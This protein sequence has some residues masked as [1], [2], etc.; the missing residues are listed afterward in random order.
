[1]VNVPRIATADLAS[2]LRE[3]ELDR[4]R[5]A[6]HIP[7]D[8]E[9]RIPGPEWKANRPPVGWLCVFE[10]QLKGGLRFP[11]PQFV[12]DV[13]NFF[14]VPLAQVVPNG[15]RIVVRF[16]LTCLEKEIA[17][18][19]IA[20]FRYFFQLK[21]AAQAPGCVSFQSRGGFRIRTPYNNFYCKKMSTISVEDRES[22]LLELLKASGMVEMDRIAASNIRNRKRSYPSYILKL[23]PS[24]RELKPFIVADLE[25]ILINN[26]HT[27]YAAGLL[28]VRPGEEINSSQ[29]YTNFSEDHSIIL[30]SFEERSNKV[31]F[32]LVSKI[33]SLVREERE[34]LTIYFHN[35][36]RFDGIFLLKHLACNHRNY[37][38]KPLV[39][40]HRLYEISVYSGK[41][42]LFRL[43]DSLNLLP[44][45]LRSLA[46][47]LCPELGEKGSIP[48]S[49]IYESHL[50]SMKDSL[51][52]YMKQDIL[53]LGGVMHK[54]QR[55][56]Y[57]LF[58]VD[59]VT[60]ITVSS[61]ALSIFRIQYYNEEFWP[62][63]IPNKNEDTFIRR[64][65]YG[66]H[67]DTY[68]P[69]G[70]DLYY[71]DV[72][73]LYPY[74]MQ[75]YPMPG[76]EPVWH[77]NL[78]GKELDD[79]LF[80]FIE[81]YI[82]CPAT[83]NKPFLP[84]KDKNGTLIFPTGK[85]VGVYYTEELKYAKSLGYTV[86]PISGYLYEKKESPFKDFVT[87][88]FQNRLEA[89]KTGNDAMSYVY[90]ILMNSLYG[91]FG[92]NPFK[93]SLLNLLPGFPSRRA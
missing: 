90:K 41:R 23:K 93:H 88:L 24:R 19:S 13:L 85:F 64:G 61:L 18:P 73:S 28:L 53:L 1:M 83:I 69:Y 79:S 54:A 89:K 84:Y 8:V 49:E 31:L 78:V 42:R 63:Y 86:L 14:R 80:G 5:V 74:V 39:R 51:I 45:S 3:G 70:E 7:D 87:T 62:I 66:G 91:R 81:A 50:V 33:L 36:S 27:P 25:T 52:D 29:I 59:I 21:K 4:L 68:K 46:K 47:N 37:K 77:S 12:R 35:F 43:R 15:V 16:L 55:I 75:E 57:D 92:I 58:Q 38:L 26:E 56:Y 6:F 11:I 40:N 44:G 67:T 2:E 22:K 20:L 32:D 30:D 60:K 48:Y 17:P 76:G 71:Y 34:S 9:I 82:E 10:D 72:N 65:Y